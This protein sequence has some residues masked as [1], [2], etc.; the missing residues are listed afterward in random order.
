MASRHEAGNAPREERRSLPGLVSGLI[1]AGLNAV[2]GVARGRV[3]RGRAQAPSTDAAGWVDAGA[4][5]DLP[6]GQLVKRHISVVQKAGWGTF[7]AE[8]AV[9]VVRTGEDV[10]VFTAVC[11]HL[12]CTV[13]AS[14]E[15]FACACHHSQWDRTGRTLAGPSPRGLDLLDRCVERGRL[16]VRYQ[17]FRPGIPAREVVG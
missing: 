10:T 2:L 16:R 7:I 17:N 11:P 1:A 6:E 12:G 13:E 4:V 15:G 14:A 3:T 8:P 5:A 9:W